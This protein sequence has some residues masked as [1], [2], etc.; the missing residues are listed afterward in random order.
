MH[1][2]V[3]G[4]DFA[5]KADFGISEIRAGFNIPGARR[6]NPQLPAVFSK[7]FAGN[8]YFVPRILQENLSRRTFFHSHTFSCQFD[9]Y[10]LEAS[11]E[12]QQYNKYSAKSN[13]IKLFI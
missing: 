12:L 4:Q 8:I 10:A 7:I 11:L 6:K 9:F 5:V 3:A 1:F 13:E 2:H